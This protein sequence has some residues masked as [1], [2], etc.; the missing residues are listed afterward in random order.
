[1]SPL[2]TP[3]THL[4][5]RYTSW[6]VKGLSSFVL[7]FYY[8]SAPSAVIKYKNAHSPLHLLLFQCYSWQW[9]PPVFC[10]LLVDKLCWRNRHCSVWE[11][12]LIMHLVLGANTKCLCKWE[13]EKKPASACNEVKKKDSKGPQLVCTTELCTFICLSPRAHSHHYYSTEVVPPSC[14]WEVSMSST[15]EV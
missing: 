4:W 11:K 5:W 6:R 8:F 15:L 3:L 2:N 7:F 12:P 13:C 9:F 14:A 10:L 1:M